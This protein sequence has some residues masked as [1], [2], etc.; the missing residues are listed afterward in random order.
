MVIL[1]EP[2]FIANPGVP[3]ALPRRCS[4]A[5]Y[6]GKF[7]EQ[8]IISVIQSQFQMMEILLPRSPIKLMMFTYIGIP[9]ERGEHQ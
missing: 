1:V 7:G 9:A 8:T 6:Q 3:G 4:K 5:I 2:I